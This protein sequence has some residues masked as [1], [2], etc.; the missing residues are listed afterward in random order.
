MAADTI[1]KATANGPQRVLKTD[2][3]VKIISQYKFNKSLSM[4]IRLGFSLTDLSQRLDL[5]I[6]D[7]FQDSKSSDHCF[8]FFI[9]TISKMCLFRYNQI[10]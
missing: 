4:A 9:A 6:K 7:A 10:I 8:T 3:S 5:K 1:C 2:K